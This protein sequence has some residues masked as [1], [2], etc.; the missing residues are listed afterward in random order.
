MGIGLAL[1]FVDF[2]TKSNR[3]IFFVTFDINFV[4]SNHFFD[5][6]LIDRDW[7]T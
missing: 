2:M 3:L 4:T 7:E 1:G 6:E 5:S